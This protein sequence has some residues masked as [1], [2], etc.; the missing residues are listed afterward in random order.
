MPEAGAI[1]F[2]LPN[3][4][5]PDPAPA[6]PDP[7]LVF[8]AEGLPGVAEDLG[9]E[10]SLPPHAVPAAITIAHNSRPPRCPLA[11]RSCRIAVPR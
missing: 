1:V 8:A 11:L 6:D 7:G 2:E 3:V 5:D 9:P 10:L 4:L